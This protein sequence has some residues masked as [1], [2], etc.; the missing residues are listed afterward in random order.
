MFQKIESRKG[1][2]L[3]E[4]MVVVAIIAIL[5]TVVL[6]ALNTARDAAED[7]ERRGI[8]SQARSGA[9]VHYATNDRSYAEIVTGPDNEIE[10]LL[11]S[12]TDNFEGYNTTDGHDANFEIYGD[13]SSYCAQVTM[14]DDTDWCVSED[15]PPQEGSCGASTTCTPTS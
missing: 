8:L 13:A 9:E 6:I 5:A 3:I 1:F 12:Y 14:T 4:L 7:A 11:E 10:K 15:L 2:T